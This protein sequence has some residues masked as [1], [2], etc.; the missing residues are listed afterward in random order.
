MRR[1]EHIFYYTVIAAT[2]IVLEVAAIGILRNNGQI[3]DN[4]IAK[5]SHGFTAAVWGRTEAVKHYFSLARENERMAER[6]FSLEQQLRQYRNEYA[7]IPD[8]SRTTAG[9]FRYLH[10]SIV[11]MS[12]NKQ[13]NYLII[14]KGAEDSVTQMSG[15]ITDMGVI[16]IVDA[17]SRNYSHVRMFTSSGMTVSAR[18]GHEGATGALAWDGHSTNGAILSEIPHHIEITPGDTVYTSGFSAIFP[19]DIPLGTLGEKKLVNG[20]S[21]EI[22]VTLFE[23]FRTLRYVTVVDNIDIAELEELERK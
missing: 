6:I 22:D 21:Y 2:F 4:W 20:S 13:H 14:D 10:A 19:P 23:D 8:S 7:F 11:K 15:I 17:V 1:R 12:R 9:N 18:I 5:A 3:Q 16:G